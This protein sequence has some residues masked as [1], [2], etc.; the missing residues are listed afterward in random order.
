MPVNSV[1]MSKGTSMKSLEEQSRMLADIK[2]QV[3]M[4]ER[5][6]DHKLGD[7]TPGSKN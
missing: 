5:T 3:E 6:L 7:Q 4:A 1:S 2:L